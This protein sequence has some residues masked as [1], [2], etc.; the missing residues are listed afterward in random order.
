MGILFATE[1]EKSR[2]TVCG[3]TVIRAGFAKRM[4]S[5]QGNTVYPE[6]NFTI[7]T[8]VDPDGGDVAN[9]GLWNERG[10]ND[11]DG[12]LKISLYAANET[13]TLNFGI[14][15]DGGVVSVKDGLI[16]DAYAGENENSDLLDSGSDRF[17]AIELMNGASLE[18]HSREN[19][20]VIRSNIYLRGEGNTLSLDFD[21]EGAV[22]EG[23]IVA[24]NPNKEIADALRKNS[25]TLLFKNGGRWDLDRDNYVKRLIV[26]NGGVV[27]FDALEGDAE[28]F[29]TLSIGIL[30]GEDTVSSRSAD[31]G[32]FV[33]AIDPAAAGRSDKLVIGTHQGSH[34]VD[35]DVIGGDSAALSAV[36]TVFAEVTE[37]SGQFIGAETEGKLFWSTYDVASRKEA[38]KTYWF[39]DSVEQSQEDTTTTQALNVWSSSNYLL[40]RQENELVRDRLGELRDHGLNESAS[41]LW[42]RTGYGKTGRKGGNGFEADYT[43]FQMG[44]DR[45]L[46][47]DRQVVAGFAIDYRDGN[48]DFNSG[49]YDNKA[50]GL[51]AYVTAY[52]DNGYYA[53]AVLRYSRLSGEA[54]AQDTKGTS[55]V[56]DTSNN[57][58]AAS[59]E[60]GRRF[61]F[62]Q[63]YLEP[64]AKVTAGRIFSSDEHLSNG[65]DV[66]FDDL[67]SVVGRIGLTAGARITPDWQLAVKA[68]ALK[69]F[70]GTYRAEAV[71]SDASRR[72]SE[73]YD[74]A[75]YVF[76]VDT[77]YALNDRFYVYG[78][79]HYETGD[80]IRD[81]A[82]V[83]GGLRW[84]F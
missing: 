7:S 63:M 6:K 75:W 33:L 78:S 39:I 69:E 53:D 3:D 13:E 15:S 23:N 4:S 32:Q 57:T 64:H 31:Y 84:M 28:S 36:G 46:G 41:G 81:G 77:T 25:T 83:T 76:G 40:W 80:E 51:S 82:S 26:G 50:Y 74:D 9:I 43:R 45:R 19:A 52:G 54:L 47:A 35:F 18:V 11:F 65:V 79:A 27:R 61:L 42:V 71:A 24:D 56:F 59:L 70:C 2:M 49:S 58:V 29:R 73:D 1:D 72:L 34:V 30:A 10:E 12:N 14:V 8:I 37:E 60:V 16:I 55:I 66:R 17:R 44:F 68:S 21:R 38:G 22:F 48:S 62:N 67:S 20:S 5:D